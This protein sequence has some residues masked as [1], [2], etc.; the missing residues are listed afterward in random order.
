MKTIDLPLAENGFLGCAFVPE[1]ETQKAVIVVTG[2]DGGI[3]NAKYIAGKLAEQGLLTLA[4]GYFALPGLRKNLSSI[5]LEYIEKAIEWLKQYDG[6]RV[7]EISAY[8][9]SKGAEYMLLASTLFPEIQAVVALAPNYFVG[10]G[11]RKGIPLYTGTSTW[12]YR[13]KPLPYAPL[14]FNLLTFLRKSARE[15]QARLAVFYE[16]AI[17]RGIPKAALIRPEKSHARIL[18][19][20]ATEDSVWPSQHACEHLVA[21]LEKARYPFAYKHV[22]YALGSHWLAPLPAEQAKQLGRVMRVERQHPAE[23]QQAR[24]DALT[25][26]VQWLG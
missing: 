24:N 20:S 9:L 23:C 15:Q 4:V 6:G 11:I 7:K 17:R 5:P 14:K 19:L 16:C 22:N 18:L 10:E 12:T 8:G 1:I 25:Q 26:A 2:S 3:E 13:G 21:R